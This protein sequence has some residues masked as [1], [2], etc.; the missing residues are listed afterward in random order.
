MRG[1]LGV[2][3]RKDRVLKGSR[4]SPEDRLQVLRFSGILVGGRADADKGTGGVNDRF[5]RQE[6]PVC[7]LL[8]R[9]PDAGDTMALRDCGHQ[10]NGTVGALSLGEPCLESSEPDNATG[11]VIADRLTKVSRRLS[12][13]SLDY[14]RNL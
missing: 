4:T 7:I 3:D 5:L 8:A 10:E 13:H 9:S 1:C 12:F 14:S 11:G 2:Q 6:T